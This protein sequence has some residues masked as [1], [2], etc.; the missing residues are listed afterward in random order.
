MTV[1]RVHILSAV[2]AANVSKSGGTYTIKDVC[3]AID[4][5]VMNG[6][7]YPGDQLAAGV[8][9]L[10]G[11]PAP[12]GHPKNAAGQHISALNGEALASAWIGSYAKNARHEGGRTLADILV[13]EAQAKAHPD[14]LKLIERLDAAIAGTNAEPIH[15]STGLNLVE[16]K[17]NGESMG[18]KYSSIATNLQYDH[19]AILLNEQGAGT[20][21]QGVGMFL[22]SEGQAEEVETVTINTQPEDKRYEGLTGWIRKLLGNSELSFE[23]ISEG[24]RKL[25]PESTYVQEVFARYVVWVNYQTNE[26]FKQD[27]SVGSDGSVAFTSDPIAVKREVKYETIE[28]SEKDDSVKTHILAALN[29]AGI[30]TAGLDDT[31]ILTAYNALIVKP[32]QE[33]I[34]A[35]NAK[36]ATFEA[37][38]KAAE[39]AEVLTL[40]TEMA[41][42]S[43]LTVDDLQKLGLAR[44]K[45]IKGNAKVAAPIVL[46]ALVATNVDEFDSYDINNPMGVK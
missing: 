7:M 38:A 32:H 14:G 33:A 17:A 27:Y 42:N 15:V 2:N 43:S 1:K 29:A 25:L 30:Q 28:N 8:E 26:M 39:N 21:A 24:I 31:Q 9:S 46:G 3:G 19:L 18:K 34:N 44:L 45:E 12:A 37:N 36:V 6:R 4:G 5:I 22:N 16:I 35:A 40:A 23:Q 13:N 20:P 10:N 41:V 11:K